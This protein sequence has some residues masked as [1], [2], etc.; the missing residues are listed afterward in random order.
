MPGDH[1]SFVLPDPEISGD[2]VL[3]TAEKVRIS[4]LCST[5][6]YTFKDFSFFEFAYKNAINDYQHGS[7][8]FIAPLY[9]YLIKH[10]HKVVFRLLDGKDFKALGTPKEYEESL[11]S[12]RS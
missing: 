6:L 9:N 12:F 7:E 5:G 1:W 11:K 10:N 3:K 2:V 8:V 4:D